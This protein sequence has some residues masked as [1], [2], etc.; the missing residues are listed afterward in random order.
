VVAE[1]FY[2]IVRDIALQMDGGVNM[3]ALLM[4][5]VTSDDEAIAGYRIVIASCGIG[6]SF[7]F[8]VR[9][10]VAV[11]AIVAVIAVIAVIAVVVLAPR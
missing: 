10:V 2:R 6:G 1:A 5:C 7:G 8:R 4:E 9:A 11:V 3:I